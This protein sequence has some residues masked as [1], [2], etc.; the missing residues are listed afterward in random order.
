MTAARL[1]FQTNA[2]CCTGCMGNLAERWNDSA[3]GASASSGGQNAPLPVYTYDQIAYQLTDAGQA[4]FFDVRQSFDISQ[5]TTITYNISNLD[6]GGQVFAEAAFDAW[7]AASGLNFV[8]TFGSADIGFSNGFYGEGAY[9]TTQV[10]DGTIQSANV[11]I[12]RDFYENDWFTNNQ[13]ETVVYYDSYGFSTFIHEIGHAIGLAHAG[14]YNG[15]ASYPFDASYANDSYQ[16]S[17]M[18]YFSQ[19][20]NTF[21]NASYADAITPMIADIIAIQDLYGITSGRGAGN[22]TYGVGGNTG[23]YMDELTTLDYPVAFTIVDD[24]GVDLINLSSFTGAQRIDLRQEAI[25]NVLG[26]TGNMLIARGTFIENAT[27]G[28]GQDTIIGNVLGNTL[29][30]GEGNDSISGGVGNDHIFGGAQYDTISGGDG[31]DTVNGGDGQDTVFLNQGN[32]LF[33]D[34]AQGGVNGQ[35]TVF[36]GYGDDTIQGGNGDDVFR[37]EWGADI[38]F[39]RKGN[40]R[41]FGGDQF[42]TIYGGEG[43]DTVDGGNGR[44]VVYLNQGNDTYIDNTQGGFNGADRVFAGLGDDTIQ[45]GNGNDTFYGEDGADEIYG[46]LGN[47]MI[48]GGDQ[49]D[50][51]S[52]GEGNDTVD[53]GFGRDTVLLGAGNDR[54][55]DSAQGGFNG[56][57]VITGGIGADTFAFNIIMSTDTI[58]DFA[59]GSDMLQFNQGLWGGGLSTQQVVNQFASVQSGNVVFDFG[60]GRS[61]T[62][63][64]VTDTAGLANDLV[65]V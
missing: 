24:S 48:F 23:T 3:Q 6:A 35:D 29:R 4:Y 52:A 65:L 14:N 13:L 44:D 38:I 56:V 7:E 19:T 45:G 22:T 51:I 33:V 1:H 21:I 16:A 26:A 64:D 34:N 61:V 36:A 12:S 8:R 53:G 30:G 37:G 54:Y 57:D 15:N 55:I 2:C 20:D 43:N 25:S 32:D 17:I 49:F 50:F 28:S 9:A 42:D 18:S 39:G 60:N 62:L 41:I 46:R 47:D 10:S 27:G 5:N 59:S 11:V 63:L 31:N 40:D 58:T